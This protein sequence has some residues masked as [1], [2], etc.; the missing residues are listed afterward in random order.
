MCGGVGGHLRTKLQA[1]E[2]SLLTTVKIGRNFF[3]GILQMQINAKGLP[4]CHACT[5]NA[6]LGDFWDHG[7]NGAWFPGHNHDM[8]FLFNG[9]KWK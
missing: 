6:L 1:R 7:L 3:L 5:E 8:T 9:S 4:A 2:R